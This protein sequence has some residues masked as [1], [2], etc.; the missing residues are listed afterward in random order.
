[1]LL[2]TIG[3]QFFEGEKESACIDIIKKLDKELVEEEKMQ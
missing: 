3:M 2:L 1:M